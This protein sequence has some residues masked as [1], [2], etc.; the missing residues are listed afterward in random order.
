MISVDK[1]SSTPIYEQVI[2]Q[3]QRLIALDVLKDGDLLPSVRTLS[4][5]L[6]V[7]P[8]TLQKAYAELERRGL[9][10]TVPGSGRYIAPNARS[11]VQK[12]KREQLADLS[13]AVS[14][15]AESGL[16]LDDVLDHVRNSYAAALEKAEKEDTHDTG[17]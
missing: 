10:Y 6:T 14:S 5:Q 3:V 8:N 13:A 11:I 12:N 1:L 9:C 7:N 17:R 16:P 4:Q 2:T 15:L